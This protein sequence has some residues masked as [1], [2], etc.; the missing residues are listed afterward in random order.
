MSDNYDKETQVTARLQTAIEAIADDGQCTC[1][2]EWAGGKD[3]LALRFKLNGEPYVV[4]F[5]DE[6]AFE[7]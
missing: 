3:Y 6:E 2:G 5:G 7:A 1:L 4:M